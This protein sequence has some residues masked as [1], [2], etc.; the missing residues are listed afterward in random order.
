M[1]AIIVFILDKYDGVQ[2]LLAIILSLVALCLGLVIFRMYSPFYRITFPILLL[3]WC[4]HMIGT[5]IYSSISSDSTTTLFY[6]VSD[7][8]SLAYYGSTGTGFVLRFNF[9]LREW[10]TGDSILATMFFYSIF[11]FCGSV[12]WYC[13]YL[14]ITNILQLKNARVEYLPCLILL[15]WPSFLFFTAGM[16]DS[17]CFFF[18]PLFFLSYISLIT[19]KNKIGALFML[20]LSIYMLYLMRPYLLMIL[21]STFYASFFTSAHVGRKTKIIGIILLLIGLIAIIRFILSSTALTTASGNHATSNLNNYTQIM[22]RALLQQQ[23]LQEGTSF[24]M[25]THNPNLVFFF[26][27]YSFLMNLCFPLFILAGNFVG[28]LQSFENLFLLYLIYYSIK[29]RKIIP[30]MAQHILWMRVLFFFFIVGMC[31]MSLINT[32][33]GLATREKSM[34]L[35]VFLILVCIIMLISKQNG[36]RRGLN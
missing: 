24:P 7:P 14:K 3:C 13:L 12:L 29:Y 30:K 22:Q 18:I 31:F 20:L 10:L 36:G 19:S 9:Y 32:N 21:M 1:R 2:L 16:K 17:W 6:Y 15:C 11:S 35:P 23:Y 4:G 26:L 27:P 28:I 25:L 5:F 33:L 8:T 34:Y